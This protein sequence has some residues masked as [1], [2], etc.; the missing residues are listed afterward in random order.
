MEKGTHYRTE[1]S[2]SLFC[3]PSPTARSTY[4]YMQDLC[5]ED[6][7]RAK[8]T[9]NLIPCNKNE[10]VRFVSTRMTTTHRWTMKN[11]SKQQKKPM[12]L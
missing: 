9:E 4:F 1:E 5:Y 7:G 12:W 6:Q 11:W 10:K 2:I 3:V 8:N